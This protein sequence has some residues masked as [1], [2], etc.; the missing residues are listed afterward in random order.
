MIEIYTGETI[1]IVKLEEILE[2]CNYRPNHL[3]S[4]LTDERCAL[5]AQDKLIKNNILDLYQLLKITGEHKCNHQFI[6]GK[7]KFEDYERY[8]LIK[9]KIDLFNIDEEARLKLTESELNA[10]DEIA[11][12]TSFENIH[13]IEKINNFY[14]RTYARSLIF[15]SNSK[16]REDIRKENDEFKKTVRNIDIIR[17]RRLERFIKKYRGKK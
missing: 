1:D 13:E 16:L 3:L 10:C 4:N 14:I 8:K 9:R 6:I 5:L 17:T 12:L 11:K 7:I 15:N 2:W